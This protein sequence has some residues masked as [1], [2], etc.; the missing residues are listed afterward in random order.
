VERIVDSGSLKES[1]YLFYTRRIVILQLLWL[2]VLL[3]N[4][5]LFYS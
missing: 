3:K 4:Q 2:W 1:D 5:S